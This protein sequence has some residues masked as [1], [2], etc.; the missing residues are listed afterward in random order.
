MRNLL[1][2]FLSSLLAG[3][4]SPGDRSTVCRAAPS[5]PAQ[6]LGVVFVANGS[7]D[8]HT[9]STN[10]SRVIAETNTP[11]HVE[12]VCWSLGFGRYLSDHVSHGNHLVHGRR[13]AA[14]VAAYRQAYPD[15]RIFMIGHSAGTAVVL[16]AAEMLPPDSVDRIVLLASSVC[17]AYDLRPALRAARYG[18]D[19]FHSTEDHLILGLGMRIFGTAE[20]QCTTA[21]GQRGF[22]PVIA[23]PADAAL[24]NKL[25]QHQWDPAVQWSGNDGGH[26]GTNRAGFLR[27]YVLPLLTCN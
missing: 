11:L 20:G 12:T 3:C 23:C 14:Q 25:R 2:V 4:C 22:M 5:A 24:Y 10:L 26:Y 16:A 1:A 19:T 7:G 6:S 13:L 9:V 27:A 8:F 15:R 17:V 18:I 21:A